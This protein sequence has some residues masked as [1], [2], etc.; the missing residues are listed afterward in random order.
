MSPH[1][2]GRVKMKQDFRA[3]ID[4]SKNRLDVHVRPHGGIFATRRDDAGLAELI[5]HRGG[6]LEATGGYAMA[7]SAL[8]AA[9]LPLAV[10]NP[11]R[12]REFAKAVGKLAK[13][14]RL[15]A[16]IVAH[17]AAVRP[18]PR[19]AAAAEA[20][21][22]GERVTRRRQVVLM[23]VAGRDRARRVRQNRMQKAIERRLATVQVKLSG[24]DRAID[25][26]IRQSSAWQ[27]RMTRSFSLDAGGYLPS[28]PRIIPCQKRQPLSRQP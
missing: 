3:G 25:E 12:I 7:A 23:M 21:A 20:G 19:P 28:K 15:D 22:L 5:E 9:H 8:A 18:P 26:A 17:F 4:G 13:T 16:A 1:A 2:Q 14:D 27:G 10:I 24:I 6:R 11:R